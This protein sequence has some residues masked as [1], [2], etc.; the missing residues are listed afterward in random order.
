MGGGLHPSYIT[1][2]S[3]RPEAAP[4]VIYLLTTILARSQQYS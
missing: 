4:A 1:E 3:T 2:D